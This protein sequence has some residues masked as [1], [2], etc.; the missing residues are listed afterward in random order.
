MESASNQ[1]TDLQIVEI[2]DA[3]FVEVHRYGLRRCL[4]MIE[5]PGRWPLNSL[6]RMTQ[7]LRMMLD[8]PLLSPENRWGRKHPRLAW[9]GDDDEYEVKKKAGR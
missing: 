5:R 1:P 2:S 4:A 6:V 9:D 3:E 8:H 7:V